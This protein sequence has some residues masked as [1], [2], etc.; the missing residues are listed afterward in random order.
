[1]DYSL[2]DIA[3]VMGGEKNNGGFGGILMIVI[4][5]LFVIML[6]GRGFGGDAGPGPAYV[7]QGEFTAGLNNITTQN[8]LQGIALSSANNNYE[9]AQ[10]ISNQTGTLIEQ[11]NAN[12]INAIQGFNAVNLSIQNQTN[13]L[14]GQIQAL[15]AKMDNCCCEIKTQMLQNRLDDAQAALVAKNADISNYNQSQYLLGQLGRFVAWA[16]TGAPAAA[17]AS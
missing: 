1:M 15:Q 17:T 5:F 11:N 10:L 3:S 9:T 6:G 8:A 7:T 13:V 4:V 16:G 12:L 2:S 14:A